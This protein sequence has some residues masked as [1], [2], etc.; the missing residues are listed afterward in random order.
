MEVELPKINQKVKQ[1]DDEIDTN[2]KNENRQFQR[3]KE[4]S[5][6]MGAMPIVD[7]WEEEYEVKRGGLLGLLGMS[8][9]KTR[10]RRDDS[11][12]INWIQRKENLENRYKDVQNKLGIKNQ[13][14]TQL[15]LS[16]TKTERETSRQIMEYEI[17]QEQILGDLLGKVLNTSKSYS[18]QLELELRD[19]LKDYVSTIHSACYEDIMADRDEIVEWIRYAIRTQQKETED[20]V[21]ELAVIN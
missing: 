13:E 14:L 2:R 6:K 3:H 4:G 12:Q 17:E 8:T 21:L 10:T 19:Y 7:S 20:K 11:N 18:R 15:R 16:L 5:K 1:L 9:T